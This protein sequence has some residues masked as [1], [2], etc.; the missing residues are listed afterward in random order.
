MIVGRHTQALVE[1]SKDTFK[2]IPG[3]LF[4]IRYLHDDTVMGKALDKRVGNPLTDLIIVIIQVTTTHVNH[5][6]LQ[7]TYLV[8][9][10]IDGDDRQAKTARGT[11]FHDILLTQILG[12]QVLTETKC[13]GGKPRLLQLDQDKTLRTGGIHDFRR[14]IDPEKR[15]TGLL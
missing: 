2:M 9:Q 10:N 15:Y 8:T 12:S 7:I 11:L 6:L 5:R 3:I 1:N 4:Q 14:E 13:L